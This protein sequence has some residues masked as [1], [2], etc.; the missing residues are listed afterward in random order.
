LFVVLM[1][2]LKKLLFALLLAVLLAPL[3]SCDDSLPGA[4]HFVAIDTLAGRNGNILYSKLY[5]FEL[6]PRAEVL[7]VDP[8][9]GDYGH[10]I[11]ADGFMLAEPGNDKIIFMK[12]IDIFGTIEI[13]TVS[14]AGTDRSQVKLPID[15]RTDW[16]VLGSAA[17]SPDGTRIA[18]ATED[19]ATSQPTLW[20]ITYDGGISPPTPKVVA[21]NVA[22]GTPPSFSPDGKQLAYFTQE[23]DA[24]GIVIGEDGFA[25][26]DVQATPT[27]TQLYQREFTLSGDETIDW[28]PDGSIVMFSVGTEVRTY[29]MA[30]GNRTVLPQA[31][32]AAYSPDGSK[33]VYT[34]LLNDYQL[35]IRDLR[36]GN[37]T[38][39]TDNLDS[40]AFYPQW[41]PDGKWIV[42]SSRLATAGDDQLADIR[43]IE[44]A[45]PENRR[46][47]GVEAL[48][49][50]WPQKLNP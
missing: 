13:Y 44:I 1:T 47:V 36:T 31:T 16:F 14:H 15:T 18:Y 34:D 42:Y 41:S 9:S 50:Y 3:A 33:I 29:S 21:M 30:K 43:I 35:T 39:L 10:G 5:P 27:P 12:L 32:H 23:Y 40:A 2:S 46:T 19:I 7:S 25:I 38:P 48:R 6:P 49:A 37:T 24:N 45:R 20:C 28:S 8:N 22:A 4:P 11:D 17:I 26:A